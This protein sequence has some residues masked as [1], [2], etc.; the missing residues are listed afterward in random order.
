MSKHAIA[1]D[2]FPVVVDSA[3]ASLSDLAAFTC[4]NG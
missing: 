4:N 1:D 3:H 2:F